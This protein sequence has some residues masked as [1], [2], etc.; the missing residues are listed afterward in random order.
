MKMT[1]EDFSL[2]VERI[3]QNNNLA[4]MRPVVEKELLHYDIL[5]CLDQEG[6]LDHLVFQGGTSLRLCHGGNRFSE[7]LDFVGGVDFSSASLANIK[8]CIEDYIGARYGLEVLV[9]EPAA[10]RKEPCYAKM[11]ID[12]WQISVITSPKRKDIPRQKIKIE[13]ANVPAYTKEALPLRVNYPFLPDGYGD[14]LVFTETLDEV[15]A[16][17]LIALPA[18]QKYIRYRD[19]WDLPWLQ[20]QGAEVSVELVKNKVNDYRLDDFEQRLDQLIP[21]I[22]EM[23]SGGGLKA[24]MR[25]FLPSDV[26]ERTLGKEKFESYLSGTLQKLF[27]RLRGALYG[28][29]ESPE[30]RM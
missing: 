27:S 10:L 19:I 20:Q 21:N 8:T 13:V 29:G 16:D 9:K 1:T 5:F 4:L 6:L 23:V 7:D 12:K 14:T 18:T 2:L 15:L 28:E 25:R 26:Y 3:M 22:T 30:F 17:K 11:N 24:E